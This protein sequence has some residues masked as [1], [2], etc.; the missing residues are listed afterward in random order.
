MSCIDDRRPRCSNISPDVVAEPLK[1]ISSIIV[2]VSS[3][4]GAIAT[5]GKAFEFLAGM[6]AFGGGLAVGFAT[7]VAMLATIATYLVDRC[8]P[9]EGQEEC[10]AGVVHNLVQDFSGTLEELLPF[11]AMHDRID[12]VV[13]SRYWD[14]VEDNNR[15]VHCTT[16]EIPRRSEI[17]RSYYFTERVC[18]AA[19][20]AFIGGTVGAI[21]GIVAAAF[22]AAAIGCATIVLCVIALIVAALVAAAAV[23][24]GA[25][26]GGQIAKERSDD[27]TPSYETGEVIATGHLIT[28][29]GNMLPREHD[30][31]A[32]V[33]WWVESS[34][35]SGQ[36]SDSVPNDP[37]S[38]CEIND[39]FSM[40]GCERDIIID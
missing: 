24:L 19:R 29:R 11:T 31:G 16:E 32:N 35:L 2:I 28:V 7:A 3:I 6:G 1:Q 27:S 25:L 13:K 39:E 14:V 10:V 40:D 21:G 22:V 30:H 36:V 5:A 8:N 20:G 38:Y 26:V 18:D 9:T 15:T 12:L 34:L 17:M 23:L 37:Y 4:I 33:F